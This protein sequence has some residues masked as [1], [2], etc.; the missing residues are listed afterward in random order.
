MLKVMCILNKNDSF[1][2]ESFSIWNVIWRELVIEGSLKT[3]KQH[4]SSGA[5]DAVVITITQMH[6]IL[7]STQVQK[8][9]TG[10]VM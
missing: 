5:C 3:I 8:Q 2:K 1:K 9:S 4:M 6:W 10:G 7:D